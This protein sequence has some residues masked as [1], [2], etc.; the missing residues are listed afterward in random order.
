VNK[1]YT[2]RYN[3]SIL[4]KR[5]KNDKIIIPSVVAF[6]LFIPLIA[7]W[8]SDEVNWSVGDFIVMGILL[9][10]TGLICK[11]AVK[12]IK[13]INNRYL[14]IAVIL[15]LFFLIWAELAVGIFGTLFAGS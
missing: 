11:L 14:A 8:F 4:K 7:M 5:I 9:Y 1:K 12:R 3:C 10:G 13:K 2:K 6:L 15:L